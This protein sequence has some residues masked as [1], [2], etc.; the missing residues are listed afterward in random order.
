VRLL[1]LWKRLGWT[2]ETLR[3]THKVRLLKSWK[4]LGFR[5]LKPWK[6]LGRTLETLEKTCKFIGGS[7]SRNLKKA[8]EIEFI[9]NIK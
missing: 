7:D 2:L 6:R 3:K 9:L 4:R 1:K 5:L 8:L